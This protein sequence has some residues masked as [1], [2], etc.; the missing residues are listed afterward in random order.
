MYMYEMFV[1]QGCTELVK[2]AGS[3]IASLLLELGLLL[4]GWGP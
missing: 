1:T 3:I 2:Q 4:P